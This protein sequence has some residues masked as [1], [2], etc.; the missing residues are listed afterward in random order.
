MAFVQKR[1]PLCVLFQ[2]ISHTFGEKN[3]S[4]IAT[5]HYA[6]SDVDAGARNV[7]LLIQVSDFIDGAAVNSHANVKLGMIFQFLANF[8]RAQNR[9]FRTSATNES[10]TVASR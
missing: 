5:I 6:L 3:V 10:A 8:Q 4:G 2:V 1:T 7:G 9:R